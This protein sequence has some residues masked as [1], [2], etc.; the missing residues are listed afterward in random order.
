M[1]TPTALVSILL[2]TASTA[3]IATTPA[4]GTTGNPTTTTPTT[5]PTTGCRAPTC[6]IAIAICPTGL[7]TATIRRGVILCG[8]PARTIAAARRGGDAFTP[9]SCVV[10]LDNAT[11]IVACQRSAQCYAPFP[12]QSLSRP[13]SAAVAGDRTY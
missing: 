11:G 10:P 7:V 5:H 12:L 6:A 3:S 9:H 2:S 13:R 1:R 4:P 8:G